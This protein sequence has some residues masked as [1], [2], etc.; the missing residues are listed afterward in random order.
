MTLDKFIE[1]FDK[2]SNDDAKLKYVKKHII[3]NYAPYEQKIKVASRVIN[4]SYYDNNVFHSNSPAK[5]LLIAMALY[6]MYT[7]VEIDNVAMVLQFDMLEKRNINVMIVE[8]LGIE[9]DRFSNVIR[10]MSEDLILNTR[11]LTSFFETKV[12]ALNVVFNQLLEMIEGQTNGT[13]GV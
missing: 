3:N 7:D 8:L 4:A 2:L 5:H 12:G 11:D 1:G 9:Y 13:G 6:E 10:M